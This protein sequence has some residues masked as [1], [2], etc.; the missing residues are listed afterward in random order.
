MTQNSATISTSGCTP[1]RLTNT[2]G[3]LYR[4]FGPLPEAAT[5]RA[6]SSKRGLL[7]LI[8]TSVGDI[9]RTDYPM[10]RSSG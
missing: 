8:A 7:A 4:H 9:R 1:L 3:H 2:A 10:K 5:Q 6:M